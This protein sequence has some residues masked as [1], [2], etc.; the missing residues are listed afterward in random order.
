MAESKSS[1]PVITVTKDGPYEV[2]GRLPFIE[3][4]IAVNEAGES[5]EWSQTGEIES[6]PTMYLCRC[7]KSGNKPFCDGTHT[8][9]GWSD[10]A[11]DAP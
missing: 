8:K 11:F 9:I 7:G 6:K 1:E 10:G 4:S 3:Q 5:L 2:K